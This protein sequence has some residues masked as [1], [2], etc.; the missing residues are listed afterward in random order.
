MEGRRWKWM[1]TTHSKTHRPKW[2]D[3]DLAVRNCITIS[4]NVV[5][6]AGRGRSDDEDDKEEEQTSGTVW[7][8]AHLSRSVYGNNPQSG[9]SR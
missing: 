8:H 2:K 1:R 6:A 7:G 5:Y 9:V 4:S 3:E